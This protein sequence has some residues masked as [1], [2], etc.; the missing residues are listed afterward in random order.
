MSSI[1]KSAI[2]IIKVLLEA[3]LWSNNVLALETLIERDVK[4]INAF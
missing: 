1:V 4:S 2:L 3:N